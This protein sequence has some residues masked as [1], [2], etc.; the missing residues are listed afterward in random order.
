MLRQLPKAKPEI[1]PGFDNRRRANWNPLLAIAEACGGEWKRAAWK[2]AFA[3]EAIADTFDPSIG[4]E[5]LRAIEAAFEVQA[6]GPRNKDRIKSEDLIKELVSD[7]TAPWAT[8]NKGKPISERQIAGLL[9]NY[10]IDPKTIRFDI[11]LNDGTW[12]STTTRPAAD[13]QGDDDK[14]ERIGDR[15]LKVANRGIGET[16]TLVP[17]SE[18]FLYN[19]QAKRLL[20]SHYLPAFRAS[21]CCVAFRGQ[22]PMQNRRALMMA[23]RQH[24]GCDWCCRRQHQPSRGKLTRICRRQELRSRQGQS[25]EVWAASRRRVAGGCLRPPM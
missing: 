18:P 4:V 11:Q 17:C 8:Y 10:E 15:R 13:P 19:R 5:L 23:P 16:I 12:R 14:A 6:R 22:R 7:A 2:A 20:L 21:Q 25:P 24:F 9:K 1:P 3:I